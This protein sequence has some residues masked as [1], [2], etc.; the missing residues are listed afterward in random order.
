MMS[1]E[2]NAM[3]TSIFGGFRKSDVIAYIEELQNNSA[4]ISAQLD[5]KKKEALNLRKS[6]EDLED[7]VDELS[8]I[9]SQIDEKDKIIADLQ[10]KLDASSKESTQYRQR[11]FEY[12]DKSEKLARAEK[13]IGAAYIDARRYSDEII[14]NAKA[15]AKDVGALASQDV[16][17]QAN[18]IEQLLRDVDAVSK[19]FNSSLEQLHKDVYALSTKLNNSASNLLNLHTELPALDSPSIYDEEIVE[20]TADEVPVEILK[21]MPDAVAVEVTD[22]GSGLTFISYEPNSEFNADLNIQ[23]ENRTNEDNN[24]WI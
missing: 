3:K 21:D 23:P 18:E 7:K 11:L 24:G 8:K 22:D 1:K 19:K 16:K 10:A 2:K 9:S 13:Q 5:E 20:D 6:I 15:K 17:H 12:Q 14:D 4:E